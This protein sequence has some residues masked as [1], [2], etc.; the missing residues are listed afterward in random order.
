MLGFC[1]SGVWFVV[2]GWFVAWRF[3]GCS[4]LVFGWIC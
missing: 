2:F 1:V 3:L 4:D